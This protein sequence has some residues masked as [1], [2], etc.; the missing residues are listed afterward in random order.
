VADQHS[1]VIAEAASAALSPLGLVRK[2]RSRIW[3]DDQSWWLGVAE[4]K[5]SNWKP[6]AYL[7]V[8]LMFLWH[9]VDR[10]IFEIGGQVEGFS[11]ADS[12]DFVQ[13]V[14][15]KA[16]RAAQEIGKLRAGLRSA[17]DVIRYYA[18]ASGRTSIYGQVNLATALALAGNMDHCR[19]ALDRALRQRDRAPVNLKDAFA[20]LLA[21]REAAEDTAGFRSWVMAATQRTRQGLRLPDGFTLPQ[22]PDAPGRCRTTFPGYPAPR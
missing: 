19:R 16:E 10:Y 21:A 18:Q 17:D 5:P 3:L 12:T 11:P 15:A 1:R 9:P 8:G 14:Q 13:A 22:V 7:N 6:G 2:G 4:F 20:W